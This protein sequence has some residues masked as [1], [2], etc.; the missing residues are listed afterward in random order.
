MSEI[1]QE[2][3]FCCNKGLRQSINCLCFPWQAI[4]DKI[5]GTL[6]G[7]QCCLIHRLGD[8]FIYI[9]NV[10]NWWGV[11]LTTH[12]PPSKP[13]LRQ[14][15]HNC[16]LRILLKVSNFQISLQLYCGSVFVGEWLIFPRR[17]K[18]R[19]HLLH[20]VFCRYINLGDW[21][22]SLLSSPLTT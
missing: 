12:R 5:I 11:V 8:I 4:T 15:L 19:L 20:I 18:L 16:Q 13:V 9:Y 10:T 7:L 2:V 17:D 3:I 14:N 21:R 6:P 22:T 1:N